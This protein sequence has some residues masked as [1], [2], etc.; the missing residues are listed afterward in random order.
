MFTQ[1]KFKRLYNALSKEYF[2]QQSNA[3]QVKRWKA[4]MPR[5]GLRG[6]VDP[7]VNSRPSSLSRPSVSLRRPPTVYNRIKRLENTVNRIKPE[8]QE[9]KSGRVTLSSVNAL[10]GN[11][12]DFSIVNNLRDSADFREKVLGDKWMSKG[13][14]LRW[15]NDDGNVYVNRVVV[16]MPVR[17]GNSNTWDPANN[18]E[19]VENP[20]MTAFKVLYDQTYTQ[21]YA[22][23]YIHGKIYIPINRITAINSDSQN[24][25]VDKGQIRVKMYWG[26]ASTT[27]NMEYAYSY[28]F[29]NI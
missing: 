9:F 15:F 29:H 24:E 25:T 20:D 23:E 4:T 8:L 18:A 7:D 12:T 5:G 10:Y 14:L 3:Y 6:K 2:K 26:S 22:L 19:F 28:F 17:A 1:K 11:D 13:L 27:T 21:R 16:Y